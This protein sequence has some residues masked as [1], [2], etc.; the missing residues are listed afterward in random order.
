M[1][2]FLIVLLIASYLGGFVA[3]LLINTTQ[4]WV[5]LFVILFVNFLCGKYLYGRATR[6][7]TEWAL[8]GLIGNLNALLIFWLNKNW[9]GRLPARE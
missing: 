9:S 6:N 1:K 7:K 3:T 8:F 2:R 5:G 4:A